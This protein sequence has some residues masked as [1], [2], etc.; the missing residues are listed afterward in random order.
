MKDGLDDNPIRG[1][2]PSVCKME[3]PPPGSRVQRIPGQGFS[4]GHPL[5]PVS[6]S[7]WAERKGR[8]RPR[9]P[10]ECP[11][12]SGR[13]CQWRDGAHHRLVALVAEAA[14]GGLLGVGVA[15]VVLQLAVAGGHLG[16]QAVREVVQDAH[17]VLHGL[18][19][20]R[21]TT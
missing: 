21:R 2:D 13:L 9:D 1:I 5:G 4:T 19:T 12:G 11:A 18:G 14:G 6:G 16:I 10:E 8:K 7:G 15:G 17:A 3:G 20:E